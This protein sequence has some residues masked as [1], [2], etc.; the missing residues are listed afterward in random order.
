MQQ[1]IFR[2]LFLPSA[3][4]LAAQLWLAP[5]T[6]AYDITGK[7][8]DSAG[9]AIAD[10]KIWLQTDS[11]ISV[12]TDADGVFHFV[13]SASALRPIGTP[14]ANGLGLRMQNGALFLYS[15]KAMR[16]TLTLTSLD[17]RSV[18]N[19]ETVSVSEGVNRLDRILGQMR[20][21]VYALSLRG[22]SASL[23]TRLIQ[24]A[25]T[26]LSA[27]VKSGKAGTLS[28]AL[29][30]TAGK[31]VSATSARVAKTSSLPDLNGKPGLAVSKSGYAPMLYVPMNETETGVSVTLKKP[32]DKPNHIIV[33]YLENWSFDAMYGQFPGAEGLTQAYGAEPQKDSNNVAYA[34]L[35]HP[36]NTDNNTADSLFPDTLSNKQFS[37]FK[38][39][40]LSTVIPDL[41]HRFY[42]EQLQ[43]HGG[44]MDQF[45]AVSNARGL[46]MGYFDTDSLPLSAYAKQYTLCDHFFHSAFGGS[47]LNHQWLVAARTPLWGDI[48]AKYRA[49]L[50]SATGMAKKKADRSYFDGQATP[51]GN[52]INTIYTHNNPHPPTAAVDQLVPDLDY[53][54][55]GDR[56]N[57]KGISWGWYSGGW[58]SAMVGRF[59]S[60]FQFHHQPFAYFKNYA[61]GS[62]GKAAHLKDERDFVSALQNGTL[63]AVSFLK[64]IGVNNEHPDYTDVRTG[65]LH[66]MALIEAIKSSSIWNDAVVIITYDEN[67]G[68]YDHVAPPVVDRWGPGSRVPTLIVSPFAKKGYVDKHVYETVSILSLIERR[69]GLLPLSSRDAAAADLTAALELP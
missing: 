23:K 27:E 28:A 56:L 58:D 17:G 6:R 51:E 18:R 61:D 32:I 2:R 53:P 14:H 55:I 35:P 7:V 68:F 43:I 3:A 1:S 64:P 65:E 59:D 66:T 33:L 21:G 19:A 29:G 10:A 69:Y 50:D 31:S 20:D 22:E 48:P 63:P 4:V 60:S 57:E 42:Q 25:N 46:T 54:T 39:V 30:K 36:W 11:A 5:Q 26:S 9:A 34:T 38:Y 40:G 8:V 41:V 15:P 37:F 44:K 24:G 67:G 12:Q 45:A 52:L 16:L 13:G 62:P 47:F 49:T